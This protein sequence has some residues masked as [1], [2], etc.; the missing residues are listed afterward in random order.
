MTYNF[1]VDPKFQVKHSQSMVHP[2]FLQQKMIMGSLH[3][4]VYHIITFD[5]DI[6]DFVEPS[7]EEIS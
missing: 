6:S 5:T 2:N 7:P 4:G 1:S 3:D